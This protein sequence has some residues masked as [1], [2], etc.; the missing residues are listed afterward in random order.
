MRR[1]FT[2][3]E[4]CFV[5]AILALL[6]GATVPAYDHLHRRAKAAEADSML[7]AIA[8]AQLQLFR[9]RGEYLACPPAGEV[10][11]GLVPWSDPQGC[12]KAMGIRVGG[13]VRYRYAVELLDGSFVA[14]AE[15]DLDGDGQPSLYRLDGRSLAVSV[16]GALE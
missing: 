10:P 3:I 4:L 1:A 12:W 2:L 6:M 9:D 15:G 5:L 7:Q 16:E 14:T 11:R 8:H 13:A